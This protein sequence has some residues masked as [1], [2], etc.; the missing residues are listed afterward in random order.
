[1]TQ[2]L[3]FLLTAFTRGFLPESYLTPSIWRVSKYFAVPQG[4]LFRD[5]IP[6]VVLQFCEPRRQLK[7]SVQKY[8]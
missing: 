6:R 8:D 3:V 7:S 4:T 5:A 1:M 2:L